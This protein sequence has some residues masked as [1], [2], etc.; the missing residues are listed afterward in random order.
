MGRWSRGGWEV[1]SAGSGAAYRFG[2]RRL[3][4]HHP[5]EMLTRATKECSSSARSQSASAVVLLYVICA[6]R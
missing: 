2:F 5:R 1:G 4:G 3:R 6:N